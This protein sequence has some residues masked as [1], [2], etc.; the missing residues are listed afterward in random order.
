MLVSTTKLISNSGWTEWS[1]IQEGRSVGTLAARV[2]HRS[3]NAF[4]PGFVMA[5]LNINSSPAHIDDLK[6]FIGSSKDIPYLL[7]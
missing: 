2:S 1:T 3:F 4:G 7:D 5:S 6:I